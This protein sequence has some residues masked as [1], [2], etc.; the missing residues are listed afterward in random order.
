MMAPKRHAEH[1][2]KPESSEEGYGN[3]S[4][5]S[6]PPKVLKLNKDDKRLIVVLENASLEIVKVR[7]FMTMTIPV[8]YN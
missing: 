5:L 8:N 6:L 2:K 4:T 1:E 3:N 7:F